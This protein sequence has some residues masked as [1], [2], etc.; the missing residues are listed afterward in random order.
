M[1]AEMK[2]AAYRIHYNG[3]NV[4]TDSVVVSAAYRL[5]A[6]SFLSLESAG[7]AG[8]FVVQDL[9]LALQLT[10]DNV[11]TFGGKPC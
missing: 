11:A 3:Y 1:E 4:A 2:V 6:L 5:R 8:N 10:R 9:P 7:I